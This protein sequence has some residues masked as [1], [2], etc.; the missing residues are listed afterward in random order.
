MRVTY[1][2]RLVISKVIVTLCWI[3]LA[4]PPFIVTISSAGTV[5]S[6]W[7]P[8]AQF[9]VAWFLISHGLYLPILLY[10]IWGKLHGTGRSVRV[11]AFLG[12]AYTAAFFVAYA[13][14]GN[15]M[16]KNTT[17]DELRALLNQDTHMMLCAGLFIV[18][19][20][21]VFLSLSPRK[22]RTKSPD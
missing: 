7:H 13:L 8:Q 5:S 15:F 16:D 3:A 14:R 11:A 1:K 10:L 19:L 9:L 17:P 6:T 2:Y 4:V 18:L 22:T 20:V 21:A 12:M